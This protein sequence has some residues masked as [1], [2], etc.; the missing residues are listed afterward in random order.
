[1]GDSWSWSVKK[2][3]GLRRVDRLENL[4]F[5]EGRHHR[6]HAAADIVPCHQSQA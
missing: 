2:P 5:S 6:S 3:A 4:T 1:M